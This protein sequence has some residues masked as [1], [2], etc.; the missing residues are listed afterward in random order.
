THKI[1]YHIFARVSVIGMILA[2]PLL[3][4]TL[5]MGTS[6]NEASRWLMVPFVNIS[7]QTSDLAKLVLIV[8]TARALAR[9]QDTI[10]D[11]RTGFFPVILP[12]L[13]VTFLI[14][15]ANFSTAA[16]LLLTC[17]VLMFVGKVR[18]KHLLVLAAIAVAGLSLFIMILL[19]SSD[20]GRLGTWKSRVESFIG[21]DA[22]EA[23]QVEQGKIAIATGG[24]IGKA[25]GNSVQRNFLPHPYSDFIFAII[26]EEYGLI[27]GAAVVLLYL[28]L[29]FRGIKITLKSPTL[30]GGL[31][32]FGLTFSIVFQAIV[33]MAVAVDLLPVTG[34]PLPLVSM[35]GTSIL[36]TSIAIGIILSVSRQEED[37]KSTAHAPAAA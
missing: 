6:V 15:P 11:L 4:V 3:F 12:V 30:F 20:Q 22:D 7:F 14:L 37:S 8:F 29:L 18:L 26:V 32:A 2:L 13:L 10:Q 23:F 27:G 16:L 21:S 5:F 9:R 34:Q 31:M 17:V 1:P 35:G 36:F 24:I 33:N 25:P 28:I 19:S